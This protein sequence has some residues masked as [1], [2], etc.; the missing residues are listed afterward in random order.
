M[1]QEFDSPEDEMKKILLKVLKEAF[2]RE[3][4]D[5]DFVK[6]KIYPVFWENFWT[7]RICMDRGASFRLI[8][9]TTN[10]AGVVGVALVIKKLI[11]FLKEDDSI[12]RRI[13]FQTIRQIAEKFTLDD[14]NTELEELLV[15]AC[16]FGFHQSTEGD[17]SILKGL[18]AVLQS[19]KLRA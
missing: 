10:L 14:V 7:K 13:T 18:A 19:I 5:K 2:L 16:L 9:V 3:E 8:E 17:D 15:D 12:L 11:F 6:E 1:L 4:V